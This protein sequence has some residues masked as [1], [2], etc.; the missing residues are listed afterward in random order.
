MSFVKYRHPL[1]QSLTWSG[2]G[3]APKW[4]DYAL[5]NGFSEADLLVESQAV[6]R[7]SVV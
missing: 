7:K 5:E 3:R 4:Y 2:K 6:D 1:D